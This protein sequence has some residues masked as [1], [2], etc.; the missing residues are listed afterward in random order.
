MLNISLY[1]NLFTL[2][3]SLTQRW[4]KSNKACFFFA[5]TFPDDHS[6]SDVSR[7]NTL[8]NIPKHTQHYPASELGKGRESIEST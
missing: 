6:A 7:E 4:L 1:I 3:D 5:H 2:E 8:G